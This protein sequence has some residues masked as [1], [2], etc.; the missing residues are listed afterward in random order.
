MLWQEFASNASLDPAVTFTD[1][2][3]NAYYQEGLSGNFVP[4]CTGAFMWVNELAKNGIWIM[5]KEEKCEMESHHS[6]CHED[7]LAEM[8]EEEG[9]GLA[10]PEPYPVAV[11]EPYRDDK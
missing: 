2:V 6:F 7:M 8:S 9:A 5:T 11:P 3:L 10:V 1:A 4:W